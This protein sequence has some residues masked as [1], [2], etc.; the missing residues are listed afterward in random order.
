MS[1]QTELK[2][3]LN[4]Y[5][6][7]I[8]EELE[9]ESRTEISEIEQLSSESSIEPLPEDEPFKDISLESNDENSSNGN[10]LEKDSFNEIKYP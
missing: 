9:S 5:D 10:D 8:E 6:P 1:F 7:D 3:T 4:H 2:I